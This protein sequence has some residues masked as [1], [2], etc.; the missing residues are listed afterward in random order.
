MIARDIQ[1]SIYYVYNVSYTLYIVS[2][3]SSAAAEHQIFNVMGT[4]VI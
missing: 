1:S 4:G 2:G 3:P